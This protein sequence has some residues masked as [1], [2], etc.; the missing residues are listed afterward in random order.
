[1]KNHNFLKTGIAL[2][3]LA[4]I[5]T[6]A[7]IAN[8]QAARVPG[9][10]RQERQNQ[11]QNMTPEQRAAFQ[12][13]AQ[14]RMEQRREEQTRNNLIEQGFTNKDSQNAILEFVKAQ[15]KARAPIRE[16][17]QKLTEA[18]RDQDVTDPEITTQLA[19][20]RTA[21]KTE[22]ERTETAEK[23]LD[24]KIGYTKNARLD[25]LLTTQGILGDESFYSGGGGGFGGRGGGQGFGGGQGGRGGGQGGR[26]GGQ[27]FGGGN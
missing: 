2:A 24:A 10:R 23:E 26:G 20:L 6:D 11:I 22:K 8:A 7:T 4:G 9:Q 15:T 3:L 27:G 21:I 14:Q 16:Q 12:Q 19:D 5:A 18:L 13:Q 25:A 1:M 17:A